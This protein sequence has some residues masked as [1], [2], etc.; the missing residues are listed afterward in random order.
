TAFGQEA[1]T[2]ASGQTVADSLVGNPYRFQGRWRDSAEGSPLVYFR[3]RY[4][5]PDTGR[6]TSRDPIGVWGDP[7]QIGNG[8]GAFNNSPV[9]FVDPSGFKETWGQWF[10]NELSVGAAFMTG[11]AEGAW[12]GVKTLADAAIFHSINSL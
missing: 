4:Y 9:N 10:S 11:A 6:F 5:N 2:A 12:T 3:A 1:I 8:Y 7:G